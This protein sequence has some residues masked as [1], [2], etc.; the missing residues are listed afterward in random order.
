MLKVLAVVAIVWI[1]LMPPLFTNGDC[2]RE[3]D[4]QAKRLQADGKALATLPA[5]VEY[6][7]GRSVP[8]RV[9]SVEQ[10]RRA[11]NKFID[12]CGPGPL[13]IAEVPLPGTGKVIDWGR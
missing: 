2:T 6:W 13:L 5:A 11:R 7:R 3:F 12:H 8:A 10:C 1:A 9:L 4:A